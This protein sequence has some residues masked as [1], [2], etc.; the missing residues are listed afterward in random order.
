MDTVNMCILR[1]IH[2]AII[3]QYWQGTPVKHSKPV[4]KPKTV[5]ESQ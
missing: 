4:T 5:A 3:T 2:S 1:C